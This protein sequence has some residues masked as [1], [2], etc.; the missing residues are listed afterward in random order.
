MKNAVLVLASCAAASL[1]QSPGIA[2]AA[3]T[4]VAQAVPVQQS[5]CFPSANRPNFGTLPSGTRIFFMPVLAI[6]YPK[7][8]VD[9]AEARFAAMNGQLEADIRDNAVYVNGKKTPATLSEGGEI[10]FQTRIDVCVYPPRQTIPSNFTGVTPD[11][12]LR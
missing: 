3:G 1:A 9:V 2:S 6:R 5:G 7:P 11:L 12:V 8:G 10:N 4:A